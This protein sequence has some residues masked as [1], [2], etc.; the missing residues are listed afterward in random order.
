MAAERS[1]KIVFASGKV[2]DYDLWSV[3]L[4]T[5]QP[6]QLTTGKGW[7]DKPKW[8]PDG[9]AVVF[10][11]S[12]GGPVGQEIYRVDAAGGEPVPLTSFGRWADSPAF[13]PDGARIAFV[14]NESGNKDLWIMDADGRNQTQ[15][16]THE[17]S[18]SHVRWTPDGRGLLFSSDRGPDA[19][20]WRLDLATGQETQ[21]NADAG[22][23]I[24]PVASPDGALIAFCS[25]RQ[26][27]PDPNDRHLDRDKDLWLMRAD[28]SLPVR[29]T[30]NQGSDFSPCWSPDG[31]EILYTADAGS[32]G[33]HLRVIDVRAVCAA[34]LA[35]DAAGAEAA[36]RR[37][38]PEEVAYDRTGMK[39]EIGAERTTTFLTHFLPSS[40]MERLYPTGYFGNERNADWVGAR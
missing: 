5:G 1:G 31:S 36:A 28:G 2:G 26:H 12:R 15:V 23:D 38:R 18:D 22:W 20:L 24:T 7:N 8:S 21:L 35:G 27:R 17:A 6:L 13:S 32:D 10:T 25:D 37:L 39:K 33:C 9:R 34:L 4:A 19:D 11:S 14:A 40:W 30:S 16:T 3:D 29:L